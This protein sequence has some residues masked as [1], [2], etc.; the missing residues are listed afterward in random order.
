MRA[1]VLPRFGGPNLFE[2]RQIDRPAPAPGQVLVRIIAASVNPVDTKIRQDGRWAHLE[3]PVVLGYDA[4]GVV[5]EVGQ[6]VTDLAAG[7]EVWFTPEIMGNPHGTYAEY[8]IVA[9]SIVA[10][11]PAHLSFEEAASVPLAGGTAWEAIVRRLQVRPGQVVLIHG[12]AGGVGSFAV[13]FARLCGA[14]VLATA[15]AEHQKTLAD[16][17]ADVP[18]D[19][20]SQDPVAIALEE[21]GGVGVDAAFDIQGPELVSRCLPSVRSFGRVA[22]ILPPQGDLRL[23]YFRN[24]TLCGVFLTRERQRLEELARAFQ[25]GQ[26]R[27]LVEQVLAL[28]RVADA[29]R[30]LETGHGRG[31]VV[32]Q[33]ARG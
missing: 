16:L 7:D 4:A 21:T 15:S 3:P 23:L 29:H 6:G 32:L 14:R 28:E 2:E 8:T 12:G 25:S 19:Y 33:V 24:I 1:M 22:C 5:E 18:I 11:K 17:G 20:R 26:V 10:R 31:K 13:Q 30:R 27:P 9:A